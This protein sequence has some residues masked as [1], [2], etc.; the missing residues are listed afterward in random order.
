MK[1]FLKLITILVIIIFAF[2]TPT[3]AESQLEEFKFVILNECGNEIEFA[4]VGEN[5]ILQICLPNAN[6][7]SAAVTLK[8]YEGVTFRDEDMVKNKSLNY[9]S[10]DIKKKPPADKGFAQAKVIGEFTITDEPYFSINVKVPEFYDDYYNIC[11]VVSGSFATCDIDGELKQYS[12]PTKSAGIK[13]LY[14]TVKISGFDDMVELK[15]KS[16]D[17]KILIAYYDEND[18]MIELQ[19]YN[20]TENIIA[21]PLDDY[22]YAKIL[23][24]KDDLI[25]P[26]SKRIEIMKNKDSI[27]SD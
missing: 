17:G 20:P 24:F 11:S 26:M 12:I 6:Y 15:A 21:K 1:H 10:F 19:K 27:K 16:Y 13:V 14:K 2:I 25:S 3:F 4:E 22:S 9:S 18:L 23:W 5:I 8:P 7:T